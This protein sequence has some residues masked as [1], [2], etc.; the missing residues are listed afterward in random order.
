MLGKLIKHE[1]KSVSKVGSIL[2]LASFVISL[3][4]AIYVRSPMWVSLFNENGDLDN[5]MSITWMLIGIGTLM[6]TIILVMVAIYGELIYLG[7]RFY[8]SMYT[9]EGYLSH[10][11]PVTANQLL[12]SKVLVSSI[13]MLITQVVSMIC[14]FLPF[15]AMASGIVEAQ[16]LGADFW[17]LLKE[18]MTEVSA[19][20]KEELGMDLVQYMLFWIVM[21]V[22]SSFSSMIVLFGAFTIGQLSKK[23][24]L[25]MGILTYF[26]ILVINMIIYMVFSMISMAKSIMEMNSGQMSMEVSYGGS[27]IV[28]IVLGAI[29]YL[30]SLKIIKNKLN[31]N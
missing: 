5:L 27:I 22:L 2:L 3:I 19:M 4:G 13:W 11:L 25:A 9:D 24:K 31:L 28:T 23:Y 17:E 12:G 1:W 7:V 29:M 26:G 6:F 20:Y 10:T 30:I 15:V 21:I 18:G 14:M 8:K 16:Q